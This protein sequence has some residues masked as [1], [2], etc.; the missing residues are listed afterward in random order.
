MRASGINDERATELDR[1]VD[2]VDL[3]APE[4]FAQYLQKEGVLLRVG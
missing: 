1:P 4:A 3:D 2:L